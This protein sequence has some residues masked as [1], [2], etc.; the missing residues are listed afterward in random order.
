MNGYR[1]MVLQ[2]LGDASDDVKCG[3][4][5]GGGN[6]AALGCKVQAEAAD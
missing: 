6:I 1:G 4:R 2:D 5:I 3:L